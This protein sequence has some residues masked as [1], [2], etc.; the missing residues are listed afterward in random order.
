MQKEVLSNICKLSGPEQTQQSVLM[1]ALLLKCSA[2]EIKTQQPLQ[3]GQSRQT[4][5]ALK[6]FKSSLLTTVTPLT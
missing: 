1:P 4:L 5:I 6:R 2:T 3:H